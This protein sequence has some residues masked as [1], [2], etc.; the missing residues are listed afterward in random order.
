M[1]PTGLP[2]G[3]AGDPGSRVHRRDPRVKV[4]GLLGVTLVSVTAPLEAWPVW[5][6]AALTLCAV[7]AMSRVPA[8]VIVRRATP[9]LPPV[10]LVA[11]F[12]PFLGGGERTVGVGPLALSD[13]GVRV[14]A[15]VSAKATIGT[16]AAVL[17]TATTTFPDVL[18]A[19]ERMR[20]PRTF[21]LISALMFRYLATLVDEVRRTRA[22]MVARG[23][24][25]RGPLAVVDLGRAVSALFLRS[26]G[27]GERVHRAMVSRGFTGV[28]PAGQVLRLRGADVLFVGV[29]V[30]A[31]VPLRI[32]LG[33]A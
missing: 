1:C 4:V 5:V 25:P 8:R 20:V 32:G 17:L 7:A 19:L 24:R 10:L 33:V 18:V 26:L 9:V 28:M 30:L 22:A 29:I 14:L 15:E 23:Y 12:A 11:A 31:M 3:L 27:R 13:H 21:T 2:A 6:A 16:F